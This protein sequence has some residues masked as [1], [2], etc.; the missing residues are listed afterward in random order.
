M[1]RRKLYS[2]FSFYCHSCAWTALFEVQLTQKELV[3][4][5]FQYFRSLVFIYL[6]NLLMEAILFQQKLKK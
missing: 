1:I 3:E 4:V 2:N 6:F 5:F